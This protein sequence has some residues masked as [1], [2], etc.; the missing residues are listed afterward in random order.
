MVHIN[1]PS[2]YTRVESAGLL[3]LT[4]RNAINPGDWPEVGSAHW[5]DVRLFVGAERHEPY[6]LSN[7]NC[8][9]TENCM[10]LGC[11]YAAEEN[12]LA[13]LRARNARK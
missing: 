8:Q 11:L 6:R 2:T 7:V 3:T 4:S 13:G 5:L 9:A 12:G 1:P 10:C